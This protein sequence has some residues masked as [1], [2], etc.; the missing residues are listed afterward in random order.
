LAGYNHIKYMII[1]S[2]SQGVCAQWNSFNTRNH[3]F[4][5]RNT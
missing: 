1:F 3:G 5:F 2:Q 4:R